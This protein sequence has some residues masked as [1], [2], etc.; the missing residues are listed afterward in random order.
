MNLNIVY[1]DSDEKF[2]K[3]VIVYAKKNDN[4]VYADNAKTVKLDK[5][6]LMNLCEKSLLTISYEGAFYPVAAYKSNAAK[7]C[8]DVTIYDLLA[9]TAAAVT[10]HS[11]EYTA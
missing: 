7:G 6:T 2:V 8:L 5:D 1:A 11:S 4:Y 3:A 10:I 9:T